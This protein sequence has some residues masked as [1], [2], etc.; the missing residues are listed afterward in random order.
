[1]KEMK[2]EGFNLKIID[3]YKSKIQASGTKYILDEMDEQTDEYVHFYFV[4]KHDE[5]EVIFD[6]VLYTL[7][8]QHE[9]ELFEVAEQKALEHFPEYQ[10]IKA[11]A[12]EGGELSLPDELEEKIGLYIAETLVELEE[13]GEIKVKEHVD[14][15]TT[16]ESGMGVDAGLNIERITPERIT[17]F[18]SDFNADTLILDEALYC[19]QINRDDFEL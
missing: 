6:C 4:G 19:F 10:K 2:N 12:E 14:L 9:S 13:E 18:I 16:H 7:R 1:M 17:R 11:D 15:D 8:F 3:E 5:V